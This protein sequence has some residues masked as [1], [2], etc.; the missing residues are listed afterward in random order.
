MVVPAFNPSTW[1]AEASEFFD[2]DSQAYIV[3]PCFKIKT[4]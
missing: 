4:K 1:E 2:K 3:K